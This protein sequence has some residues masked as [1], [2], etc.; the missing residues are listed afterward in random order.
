VW[1]AIELSLTELEYRIED[2]DELQ[3]T[4][5]GV[6]NTGGKGPEIV[7]NISQ[8]ARGSDQVSV[9]VKPSFSEA[10]GAGDPDLLEAAAAKLMKYLN[11]LLDG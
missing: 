5:R 4:V 6:S 10:G 8:V 11:D 1:S 3:G 7:L 2:S 9:Y